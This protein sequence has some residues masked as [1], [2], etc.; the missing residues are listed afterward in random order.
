MQSITPR[1]SLGYA[2]MTLESVR[3]TSCLLYP[4]SDDL[5]AQLIAPVSAHLVPSQ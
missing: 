4:A 3:Q 1:E 2:F 5:G